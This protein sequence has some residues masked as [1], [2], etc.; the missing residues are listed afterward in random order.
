VVEGEEMVLNVI[1]DAAFD[2]CLHASILGLRDR[3]VGNRGVG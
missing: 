2:G 1:E 3:D